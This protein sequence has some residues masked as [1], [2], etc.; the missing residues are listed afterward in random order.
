MD[1]GADC[2][3]TIGSARYTAQQREQIEEGSHGDLRR[4]GQAH[5]D[6]SLSLGHPFRDDDEPAGGRDAHQASLA[7]Y[8]A[9][10]PCHSQCLTAEGMPQVVDGD[11]S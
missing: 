2:S 10:N 4:I 11:R 3:M 1:I 6:A 8:R 9:M 7:G 5:A